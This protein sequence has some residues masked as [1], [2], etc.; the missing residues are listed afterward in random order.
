MKTKLISL[1]NKTTKIFIADEI[2]W[3]NVEYMIFH[4]EYL[5]IRKKRGLSSNYLHE[6][7]FNNLEEQVILEEE[8]QSI[9][10][11]L[12]CSY[13]FPKDNDIFLDYLYKEAKKRRLI[14][15]RLNGDNEIVKKSN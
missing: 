8:K 11:E 3:D 12:S 10:N 1:K 5:E 6:W 14:M 15:K 9:Y 2:F 4:S 13:R 7:F